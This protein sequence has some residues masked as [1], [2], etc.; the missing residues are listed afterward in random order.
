VN[1]PDPP[2]PIRAIV[3][4]ARYVAQ[5]KLEEAARGK[6]SRIHAFGAVMALEAAHA[7]LKLWGPKPVGAPPA[8]IHIAQQREKVC[9]APGAASSEH[10]GN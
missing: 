9:N 3:N 2:D 6:L 5:Q 8:H 7:Y 10:G 1:L 4:A